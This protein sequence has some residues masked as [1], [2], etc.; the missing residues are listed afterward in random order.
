LLLLLLLLLPLP[1][2]LPLLALKQMPVLVSAAAEQL[3]ALKW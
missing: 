1:R 2:S 3:P